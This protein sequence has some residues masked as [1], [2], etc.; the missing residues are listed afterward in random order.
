VP[1]RI[2]PPS[3]FVNPPSPENE[4]PLFTRRLGFSQ[5]ESVF[6]QEQSFFLQERS[7]FLQEGVE[8]LARRHRFL[9]GTLGLFAR[10][11]GCSCWKEGLFL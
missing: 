8:P 7:S 6:L 9:A 1:I 11:D 5:E 10:R 2:S 4:P 3:T